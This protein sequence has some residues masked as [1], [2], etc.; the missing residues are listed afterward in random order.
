M[1]LRNFQ[2]GFASSNSTTGIAMNGTTIASIYLGNLAYMSSNIHYGGNYSGG[3]HVVIGAGDTPPTVND[4]D[5]AD[6]S[7]MASDKMASLTQATSWTKQDGTAVTVQ[8]V[9][10]SNAPITVKEVGLALKLSNTAYSKAANALVARKVLDTPVTV[11][12]GETYAFTYG[13][14]V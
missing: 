11:Q 8:W 10:N 6:S 4:Y 14:K 12:P 5:L 2:T 7:I 13:L 1:L 9:N 3:P